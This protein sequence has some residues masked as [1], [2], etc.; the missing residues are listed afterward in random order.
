M[1]RLL[2][3]TVVALVLTTGGACAAEIKGKIKSVDP[4]KGTI[5]LT[6]EDRDQEFSVPASVKIT[7]LDAVAMREAKDGLKDPLFKMAKGMLAT[8]TTEQKDGQEVVKKMVVNT[9]RID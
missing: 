8:I 4:E 2:P 7:I 6:V 9:N 5:T 1:L 3:V